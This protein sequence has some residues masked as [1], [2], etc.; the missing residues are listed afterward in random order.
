MSHTAVIN[1]VE[2]APK[3]DLRQG[4]ESLLEEFRAC[5][6]GANHNERNRAMNEAFGHSASKA[7]S[8]LMRKCS[9]KKASVFINDVEYA[10]KDEL[11]EGIEGLRRHTKKVSTWKLMH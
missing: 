2:Y 5:S 1:G 10:P 9:G 8:L 11:R 6:N 4:L 7:E 3:D